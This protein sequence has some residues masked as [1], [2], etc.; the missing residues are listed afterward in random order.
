MM[1]EDIC[2][3]VMLRVL[4]YLFR[5]GQANVTRMARELGVHHRVL[6]RRMDKLVRAGIVEERRYERLHIYILK[7]R[8]PRVSALKDL[9]L[10]LRKTV[11]MLEV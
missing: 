10:E 9:L 1:L 11:E 2:E 8:D 7:L 5:E 4:Y 3:P 6:R